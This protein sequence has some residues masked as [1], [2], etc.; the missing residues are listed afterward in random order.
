MHYI[1]CQWSPY[2]RFL[3]PSRFPSTIRVYCKIKIIFFSS[4]C[5]LLTGS[6]H[7]ILEYQRSAREEVNNNTHQSQQFFFGFLSTIQAHFNNLSF[8]FSISSFPSSTY[9]SV[10]RFICFYPFDSLPITQMLNQQHPL[11]LSTNFSRIYLQH[12]ASAR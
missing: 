10:I 4:Q 5:T 1:F 2:F 12:L 11:H 7:Q 3:E 6:V 8:T 9:I